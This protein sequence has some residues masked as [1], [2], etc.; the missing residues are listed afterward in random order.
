[1]NS[2]VEPT[3]GY[4]R[5]RLLRGGPL[6]GVRI[7][8]GLPLEPWTREPMDRAPR[9]NAEVNGQHAEL[10][11][12]W[13]VCMKDPVDEATYQDFVDAAGWAQR[14]DGF[15]PVGQPYRRTNWDDSTP[16]S[17]AA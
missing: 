8:F 9:W 10:D 2:I 16:P 11:R 7:W 6:C 15:D 13:P 17:F 5:M 3:P 14:N 1:M 4:F 12:V